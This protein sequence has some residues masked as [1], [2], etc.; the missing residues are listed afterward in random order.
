VFAPYTG[1]PTNLLFFQR[2]GPTKDIWYY[3]LPLPEGRNQYTKT[4]PLQDAEFDEC[5]GLW[6]SRSETDHSWLVQVERVVQGN[7]NLDIKNPATA[8][9]LVHQSPRELVQEILEKEQRI[10]EIM[11][12]IRIALEADVDE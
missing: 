9:G 10:A 8:E 12:L 3:E 5:R 6:D 11:E 2:D 4:K 1:I 7:Y